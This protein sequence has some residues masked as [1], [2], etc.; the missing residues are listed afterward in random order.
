MSLELIKHEQ[1]MG[2]GVRGGVAYAWPS[3]Q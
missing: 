1:G 3:P 2:G